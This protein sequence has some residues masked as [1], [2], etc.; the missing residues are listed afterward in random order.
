MVRTAAALVPGALAAYPKLTA[1][2]GRVAAREN[3]AAYLSSVKHLAFPDPL[4]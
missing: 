2:V 3:I 4:A 1:F